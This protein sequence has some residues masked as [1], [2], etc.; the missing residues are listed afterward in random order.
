MIKINPDPQAF[1]PLCKRPFLCKFFVWAIL[2]L[3]FISALWFLFNLSPDFHNDD[4]PQAVI[5]DLPNIK[6]ESPQ[7]TPNTPPS[8]DLETPEQLPEGTQ[9]SMKLGYGGRVVSGKLV[10]T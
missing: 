5:I 4:A 1:K 3:I 2:I 7:L 8:P 9:P 6:T 10:K